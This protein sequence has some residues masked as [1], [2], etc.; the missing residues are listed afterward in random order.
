MT[1][2]MST[3]PAPGGATVRPALFTAF[4]VTTSLIVLLVLTQ[5]AM[6]GQALYGAGDIGVHGYVGN[7]TFALGLVAVLLALV[8]R[9]PRWLLVATG[10]LLVVL[11]AQTGLGYAGRTSTG[12]A[13][14]HIPLGVTAFGLATAAALGAILT[15]PR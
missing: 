2:S 13:S 5:A 8:A 14:I 6:A 9:V 1:T 15:R 11:F 12:A 10:L 3:V 7:A 4:Q